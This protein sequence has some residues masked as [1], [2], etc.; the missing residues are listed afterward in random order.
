MQTPE[1][2]KS[3][4]EENG[5]DWRRCTALTVTHNVDDRVTKI[6][7]TMFAKAPPDDEKG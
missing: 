3:L 1:Q 7:V 2:L 5:I 6:T 4:L